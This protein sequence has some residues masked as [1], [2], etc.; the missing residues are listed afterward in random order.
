[1]KYITVSAK[2]YT[3]SALEKREN[4]SGFDF[5]NVWKVDSS[6]SSYPV[7]MWSTKE[8]KVV[9]PNTP[10]INKIT[11]S[12]KGISVQIKKATDVRY[13]ELYYTTKKNGTYKKKAV[14]T[15]NSKNKTRTYLHR[16]GTKGRIYYYKVRGYVYQNGDKVYSK[17]S[18]SKSIKY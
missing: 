5:N 12:S 18:T 15:D 2:S 8:N 11:K 9:K 14:I 17:F 16:V 10:S 13:Y 7:F 4:Y 6:I 1:M 3:L